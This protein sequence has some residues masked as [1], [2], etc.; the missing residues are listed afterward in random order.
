MFRGHAAIVLIF[1]ALVSA[2][3]GDDG[4]SCTIKDN[5]DGTHTLWCPDGTSVTVGESPAAGGGTSAPSCTIK[6][7]DNGTK[8]VSCIDG[9]SVTVRDDQGVAGGGSSTP[10]CTIEDNGNGT[11][12]V[13]CTD[14][15]SVTVRELENG[16]AGAAE[17][18]STGASGAGDT[19]SL[20]AAAFPRRIVHACREEDT[21]LGLASAENPLDS[22]TDT[23]SIELL[24][25]AKDSAFDEPVACAANFTDCQPLSQATPGY[26]PPAAECSTG[27]CFSEDIA[28]GEVPSSQFIWKLLNQ[29]G[30]G[31]MEVELPPGVA[32]LGSEWKRA[33]AV[34]L[35]HN[36]AQGR[37]QTLVLYWNGFT[38]LKTLSAPDPCFGSSF[39]LPP[40]V[41]V[42]QPA[43]EVP[44]PELH[45]VIEKISLLADAV[46]RPEL[47]A[48]GA[49][50]DPDRVR[51]LEVEWT[52]VMDEPPAS[53]EE[54]QWH[55]STTV[56]PSADWAGSTLAKQ[57]SRLIGIGAISSMYSGPGS[58]DSDVFRVSPGRAI[59]ASSLT[60]PIGAS[61]NGDSQPLPE[62]ATMTLARSQPSDHNA[63]A[64]DLSLT[65][66]R[67]Q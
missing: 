27:Q 7:N 18:C 26:V 11:K 45:P 15:T 47:H 56:T 19:G 6:D 57:P 41:P 48:R 31:S 20:C 55:V 63:S 2:C 32:A 35:Q 51:A 22:A 40:F 9:T 66:V 44:R 54:V 21:F 13:S 65:V 3:K 10:S 24:L 52:L 42:E 58:F 17:S 30:S 14:G 4:S 34:I 25:R 36:A 37:P 8:T 1:A 12:T 64:P 61:L 33:T 39:I 28:S 60:G 43:T 53:G 59:R 46:G 5:R 49:W 29:Q 23:L 62:G 67:L 50:Y 38:R 16:E